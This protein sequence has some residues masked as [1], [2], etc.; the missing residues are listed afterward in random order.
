MAMK[1][2]KECGSEVSS[3]AKVCPK[4]GKK[5]KNIWKTIIILLVVFFVIGAIASSGDTENS[6]EMKEAVENFTLVSD[7][8]TKDSIG[9]C[10]I[11]GTIQNNTNKNYSYVQV[12]FN[13]YD[14]DGNQ[15]GTAMDN[16]NNFEPNSTW[17]YK[18]MGLTSENV[19]SYK[20]VEITGW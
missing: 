11:E 3:S 15:L 20:F 10:W 14:A 2:C 17:K 9:T 12:T 16:I 8:M 13:L 7:E 1:Y 4:C 18:A 6:N 19:K 5:Q